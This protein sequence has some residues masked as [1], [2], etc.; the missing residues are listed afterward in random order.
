MVNKIL[1]RMTFL[2]R[3]DDREL[4]R[5]ME[6]KVSPIVRRALAEKC[7]L[8]PEAFNRNVANPGRYHGQSEQEAEGDS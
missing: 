8:D 7:G 3:I 2:V 6:I 4:I 5:E 1:V